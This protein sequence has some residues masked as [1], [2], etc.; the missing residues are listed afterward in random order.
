[1]LFLF[2]ESETIIA[3]DHLRRSL[4]ATDLNWLYKILGCIRLSPSAY[5]LA[6]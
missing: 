1:M 3:R 6:H 2:S 5:L 4:L